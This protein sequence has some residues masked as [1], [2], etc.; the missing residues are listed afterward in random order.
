MK[1]GSKAQK[2]IVPNVNIRGSER[3]CGYDHVT[4]F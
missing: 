1:F 3:K 4:Q 2:A